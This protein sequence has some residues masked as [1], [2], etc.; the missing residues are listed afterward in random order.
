MTTYRYIIRN[1]KSNFSG[2]TGDNYLLT[3]KFKPNLNINSDNN[4]LTPLKTIINRGNKVIGGGLESGDLLTGFS[5]LQ[6]SM[7]L[8]P[9]SYSK[10]NV[11]SVIISSGTTINP[12]FNYKNIT[13]PIQLKSQPLD[14]SDNIDTFVDKETRKTINPIIDGERVKYISDPYPAINVSFRFYNKITNTFGVDYKFAGFT[15]EDIKGKNNFKKSFFRL[16]FFDNNNNNT[17]NL[18][19]TEEFNV[20]DT[21]TPEFDLNKI[22]W[23]KNDQIFLSGGTDSR[24]TYME[25]RFFNAKTGRVHRFINTLTSDALPITIDELS[26][27]PEWRSSKI[28]IVNPKNNGGKY[29][30]K[31]VTPYGSNT[32]DTITLTEYILS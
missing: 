8:D 1:N 23:L 10:Q 20:F 18:M 29:E 31:T 22:F 28:E 24:F 13:I 26:E 11:G 25:A 9:L 2:G 30:F 4:G 6:K 7:E 16:Y 3:Y 15:D 27:N 17:Q 5:V 12:E 19:L 32:S 14:Y 21:L